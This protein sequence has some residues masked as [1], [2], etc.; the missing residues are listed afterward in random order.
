MIFG[1]RFFAPILYVELK[2]YKMKTAIF[3]ASSHGTT[4]K[5]AELIAQKLTN[6]Q[7]QIFNLKKLKSVDL[8]DFDLVIIGGSIHAG[9]IQN[10][11][12]KFCEKNM[13]ELLDKRIALYLCCMNLPEQDAQ[14]ENAYPELLRNKAISKKVIGGEFLFDKMNFFEKAI[15]RKVSKVNDTVSKLNY[16]KIEE[17]VNEIKN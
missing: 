2:L 1:Y 5:T 6:S 14:F 11:V 10:A 4:A 16:V 17:L 12:K 13:V 9:R 8:S 3:Y 7:T 15:V